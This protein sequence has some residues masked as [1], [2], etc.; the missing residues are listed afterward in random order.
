[1]M[2]ESYRALSLTAIVVMMVGFV[3]ID[4]PRSDAVV[5]DISQVYERPETFNG[6]RIIVTG[7]I[8]G[9]SAGSGLY[10][11]VNGF[12]DDQTEF[13]AA[14]WV[15]PSEADRVVGQVGDGRRVTV[16]GTFHSTPTRTS[17]NGDLIVTTGIPGPGPLTNVEVLSLQRER[18]GFCK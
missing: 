16:E 8:F 5:V 17:P 15:D 2:R 18:F 9:R 11:S 3:N 13:D 7:Y 1:M 12:C 14:I 6:R 10:K 4:P